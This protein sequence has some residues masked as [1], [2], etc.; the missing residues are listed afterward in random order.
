MAHTYGNVRLP[1]LID[2]PTLAEHLDVT[3]SHVRR[4]VHLRRIPFIRWGRFLRFDV[5]DVD[6]FIEEST[7]SVSGT[8][9]AEPDSLQ[10]G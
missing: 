9:S 6:R 2:V 1:H 7:T 3:E 4:L 8:S 5:A 10:A